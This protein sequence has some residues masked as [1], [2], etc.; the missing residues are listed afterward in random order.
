VFIAGD[1][2]PRSCEVRISNIDSCQEFNE[3]K[4]VH[5]PGSMKALSGMDGNNHS[6]EE[7]ERN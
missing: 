2:F 7:K 4:E 3:W 5:Q 6:R 1:A